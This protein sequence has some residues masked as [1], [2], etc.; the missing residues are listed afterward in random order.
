VRHFMQAHPGA[1]R[2]LVDMASEG[3]QR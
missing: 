1:M 3:G 2:A